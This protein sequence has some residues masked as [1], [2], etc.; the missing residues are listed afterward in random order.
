MRRA[1]LRW[2]EVVL[3]FVAVGF[4]GYLFVLPTERRAEIDRG[5]LQRMNALSQSL[6]PA[7][8]EIR[9]LVRDASVW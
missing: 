8:T 4:V 9:R 7:A 6:A 2:R 3:A 5:A 1:V